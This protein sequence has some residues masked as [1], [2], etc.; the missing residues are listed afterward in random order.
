MLQT[1]DVGERSLEGY[2]GL[3][4]GAV[5]EELRR[6]GDGLRGARVLQ[7]NATPYGSEDCRAHFLDD[8]DRY[9]LRP[10]LRSR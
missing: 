8:P 10:A 7:V 1:V 9:Q 6:L 2:C 5:V 3:A 4:D